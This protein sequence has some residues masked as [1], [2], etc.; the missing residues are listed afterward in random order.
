MGRIPPILH[1]GF[2]YVNETGEGG[3]SPLQNLSSQRIKRYA[4]KKPA[5]GSLS[6]THQ[7]SRLWTGCWMGKAEP[8]PGR[9]WRIS[10]KV[11]RFLSTCRGI[12]E[13]SPVWE[14]A[15]RPGKRPQAQRQTGWSRRGQRSLP[16]P[17]TGTEGL[18]SL[19]VPLRLTVPPFRQDLGEGKLDSPYLH[20]RRKLE[21][22]LNKSMRIRMTDGRTLV[23]CFLCT[24]RDCNVILGSAQEYLKPTGECWPSL[25]P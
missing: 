3:K 24:D 7:L 25:P 8:G 20:A 4:R 6:K 18:P 17:A 22:L 9:V 11:P 16:F 19:S 21:N 12:Q 15:A 13:R 5:S 14:G 23:G 10:R 1:S 2:D